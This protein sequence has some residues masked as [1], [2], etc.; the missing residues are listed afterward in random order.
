LAAVIMHA[1]AASQ[2]ARRQGLTGELLDWRSSNAVAV[3]AAIGCGDDSWQLR[4]RA[5]AG[6]RYTVSVEDG[7]SVTIELKQ[8][9]DTH[10]HYVCDGVQAKA[11]FVVA[12]GQLWLAAGGRS[13]GFADQ[14]LQPPETAADG[15]DGR[16]LARMD[17]KILAVDVAGGDRVA[18][19]QKLLVLEAMKMEFQLDAGVDGEVASLGCAAGDQVSARQLLLTIAPDDAA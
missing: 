11:D 7:D 16:V 1:H 5:A 12:D 4:L 3:P 15:G 9:T 19:G 17:G 10:C 6:N 8:L 2:L 14:L 18:R 13:R